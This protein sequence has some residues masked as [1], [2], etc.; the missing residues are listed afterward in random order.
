MDGDLQNDPADLPMLLRELENADFVCGVR[1]R[2]QDNWQRRVSTKVARAARR[3][4][5]GIDFQ[6][7]GCFLRVFRRGS[8]EGVMPFNGW[9]RFLPVLVQAA[10]HRV[11][12]VP[13]NHRPRVAGQSKYG[14]GNRLWRGICDLMGVR[15]L[16]R[17]RLRRVPTITAEAEA[18]VE[19]RERAR[20]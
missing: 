20:D 18:E 12:E 11:R 2:R 6:D 1:V 17:R 8:L 7:T 13:V 3:W 10:G 9:H 4:V 5:L 14:I 16:L 19:V 15:W